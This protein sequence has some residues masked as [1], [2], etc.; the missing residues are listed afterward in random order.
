MKRRGPFVRQYV[1][2]FEWYVTIPLVETLKYI[3]EL[4]RG[5]R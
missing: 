4:V 3:K 5:G 2:W 1:S